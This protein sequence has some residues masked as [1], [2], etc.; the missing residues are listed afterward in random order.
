M[1]SQTSSLPTDILINRVV[2]DAIIDDIVE[3]TFENIDAFLNSDPVIVSGGVIS[4]T[5]E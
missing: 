1:R 3:R 4:R 2:W 5:L